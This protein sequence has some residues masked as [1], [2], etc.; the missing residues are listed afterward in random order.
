MFSVV[1]ASLQAQD[2]YKIKG[3]LDNN[4]YQQVYLCGILGDQKKIID[5][6]LVTNGCFDFYLNGTTSPGMYSIILDVKKDA[7]IRVLFNHENIVFHSDLNHLLDSMEITESKETRLY[8]E[9]SKFLGR[10]SR[11]TD[12]LTKISGLYILEDKF[13]KACQAEISN[14]NRQSAA[15]PANMIARSQGTFFARLL[16]AQ[17]TVKVPGNL[18]EGQRNKYLREHYLDNIDFTC[19]PLMHTDLL[20]QVIKNYL[21]FFEQK[22]F[23]QTEQEAG[24]M[25][26]IDQLLAKCAINGEMHD[27]VIRQLLEIF[28]YGNYD[29]MGAYITEK[30]MLTNKCAGERDSGN[31]KM[32]IENIR[33]VSVGKTAPEMIL[34][35]SLGKETR[36]SGF[37]DDYFL[38]VFWATTCSHCIKMLP[39]LSSIYA[40]CHVNSFE[41]L[42]YS[43]DADR[44]KWKDFLAG[45]NYQWVNYNDSLGWKSKAA[46]DFNVNATPLFFLL[47]K[48]KKI[49]AKPTDLGELAE[50]LRSL[51]I[52]K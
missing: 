15:E 52:L 24:Y 38:I 8:Y 19:T 1:V 28:M 12:L 20:P 37:T 48:E 25:A 23:T 49:I 13:F 39:E 16:A 22:D 30:Y 41:I 2:V 11:K 33:R 43:L 17:Q 7:Y 14:V 4:K 5:T 50:K 31:F 18:E 51:A 40:K 3:C 32:S 47:N 45:G 42:C 9:Y 44:K 34:K 36:L 35:D 10:S 29:I 27:F 26:G 21:T 46:R 6:A